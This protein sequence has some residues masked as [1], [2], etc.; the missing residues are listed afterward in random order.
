MANIPVAERAGGELSAP[1]AVARSQKC[2]LHPKAL[3][4][5]KQ[6]CH[7]WSFLQA[8]AAVEQSFTRAMRKPRRWKSAASA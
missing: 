3:V 2:S 6:A 1:L 8:A 4:L 7:H 5:V